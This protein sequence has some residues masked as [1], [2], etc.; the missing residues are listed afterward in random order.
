MP[1]TVGASF[2]SL[3][4]YV[5]Y[6]REGCCKGRPGEAHRSTELVCIEIILVAKTEQERGRKRESG[7]E[8]DAALLPA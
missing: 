1:Q 6:Y 4:I 7:R 8:R 5:A 2:D 3:L